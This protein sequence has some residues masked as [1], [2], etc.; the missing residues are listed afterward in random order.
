MPRVELRRDRRHGLLSRPPWTGYEIRD[1][2]GSALVDPVAQLEELV[3][4]HARGL[5]SREELDE[6]KAKV[7]GPS[8]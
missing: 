1:P 3:D 6:Q 8:D 4:L 7:L 2:W 5:M